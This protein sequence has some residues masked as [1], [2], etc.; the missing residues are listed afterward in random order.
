M[1]KKTKIFIV[2]GV[3]V[4]LLVAVFLYFFVSGRTIV[5]MFD[6]YYDYEMVIVKR[7]SFDTVDSVTVLSSQQEEMLKNL[8]RDSSFRRVISDIVYPP[9]PT[10]YE[11][12]INGSYKTKNSDSITTGE[13]LFAD[14]VGGKYLLMS[15]AFN[16]KH[17]RIYNN[18]WNARL[19]EIIAL[20]D[21]N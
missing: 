4:L 18:Q 2:V 5:K 16:G 15:N 14:S 9:D 3:I 6:G 12:R 19:D 10:S 20:S 7:S 11:I 1:K 17:L 8:F 21:G 13:F